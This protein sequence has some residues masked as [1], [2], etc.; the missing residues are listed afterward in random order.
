MK[1]LEINFNPS[2]DVFSVFTKA[3]LPNNLP[4]ELLKHEEIGNKLYSNFIK[5]C[6]NG[7][8]SV[9][10]LTKRCNL[11]K[12]DS[13]RKSFKSVISNKEVH[14]KEEKNLMARFFIAACKRPQLE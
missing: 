4:S 13:M 14:L 3:S 6:I 7:N 9:W 5:K 1:R 2:S 11:K 8:L 12:F 10:K